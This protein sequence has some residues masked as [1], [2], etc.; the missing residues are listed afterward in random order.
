MGLAAQIPPATSATSLWLLFKE[1]ERSLEDSAHEVWTHN[2]MG[3]FILKTNGQFW[4]WSRLLEVQ[5]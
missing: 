4:G 1:P 5:A 2:S 3:T